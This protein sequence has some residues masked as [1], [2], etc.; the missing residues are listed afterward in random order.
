[1]YSLLATIKWHIN[2]LS[3]KT[4]HIKRIS[5]NIFRSIFGLIF[6]RGHA[7]LKEKRE[8]DKRFPIF[9]R[10][11]ILIRF[12]TAG[13]CERFY[14][15][16][17]KSS[18]Q[19]PAWLA[20]QGLTAYEYAA[21]HGV[22]L[23][24]ATARKIG[25]EASKHGIFVSIHAPYYINCGSPEEE[26]QHASINYLLSS[27]RAVDWM[28]GNRVIF[29]VGSP[30]KRRREEVFADCQKVVRQARQALDDA[31]Y[32]HIFLCPE[33]MGRP[34]QIGTLEEILT[35]CREDERMIPTVDFGHLHAANK[36]SMTCEAAFEEVILRMIEVLGIDRCR[37]FHSHFSRIAYTAKGEKQHMTFAD[38]GFGPDF[39]HLAPIL[40][41]YD[42]KPV[43]ICES[44]GTQADDALT[45]RSIY[46]SLV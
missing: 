15:E 31:G 43:I 8:A 23:G 10:Y 14:E 18:H 34:S 38:E 7:I 32:S 11:I 28:G 12:G 13:N 29:H 3:Y 36:G 20:A 45:M 21:G 6:A 37:R 5:P 17:M 27:A 16:G 33:T 42:L 30:G 4:V 44:R 26:K 40:K 46:S 25:A 35:L 1:M 19:A 39:S 9:R 41:K 2:T 24:E 22:S